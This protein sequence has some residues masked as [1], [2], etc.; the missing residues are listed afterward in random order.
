MPDDGQPN[1]AQAVTEISERAATLIREEIELAKT[2]VTEKVTSLI[3][4]VV[5]GLA[6]GVFAVVGVLFLLHGAAWGIWLGLFGADSNQI[7]L[8]FLIVAGILFLLGGLGGWMAARAFKSGAPPVPSEAIVEAKL[9]KD[10]ITSPGSGPEAERRGEME[11]T[12]T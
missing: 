11:R 10:T 1:L 4:G 5:I 7:Y 2:E 3:K 12:G 9:I 8:G 6:A